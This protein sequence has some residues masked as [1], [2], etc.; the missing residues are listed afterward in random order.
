VDLHCQ[1]KKQ[2]GPEEQRA[3]LILSIAFAGI[4]R[5]KY[6][7]QNQTMG[8]GNCPST[9]GARGLANHQLWN[10]LAMNGSYFPF[11]QTRVN[12]VGYETNRKSAHGFHRLANRR[13]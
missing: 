9:H 2:G 7:K 13:E 1:A 5:R 12:S 10:H 6:E 3:F 8:N 11:L 4:N